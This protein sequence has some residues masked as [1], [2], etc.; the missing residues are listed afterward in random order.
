MEI[1]Y[2]VRLKDLL[3]NEEKDIFDIRSY[4]ARYRQSSLEINHEEEID[5]I[6]RNHPLICYKD[7]D[8]SFNKSNK[9]ASCQG[10]LHGFVSTCLQVEQCGLLSLLVLGEYL[11]SLF[12]K[13]RIGC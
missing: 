12:Q 11:M 9:L 7:N 2:K 6:K 3:T 4:D 1:K 8:I 5:K 13:W 10:F